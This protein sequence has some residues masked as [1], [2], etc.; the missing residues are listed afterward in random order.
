VVDVGAAILIVS[1]PSAGALCT[2]PLVGAAS[3]AGAAFWTLRLAL[4]NTRKSITNVTIEP[5]ANVGASLG[6]KMRSRREGLRMR[7]A[8][9]GVRV[10]ARGTATTGIACTIRIV[11]CNSM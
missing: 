4:A 8:I 10:K 5:V 1:L 3:I 11:A 9:A 6:E 7:V 2:A